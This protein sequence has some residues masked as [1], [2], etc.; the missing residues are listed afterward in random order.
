MKKILTRARRMGYKSILLGDKIAKE[1]LSKTLYLQYKVDVK[2]TN[3]GGVEVLEASTN[4][5]TDDSTTPMSKSKE[6]G[7]TPK[8]LPTDPAKPELTTKQKQWR[9]KLYELDT[10]V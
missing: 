2:K 5:G 1:V 6:E 4:S 3:T 9:V 10:L 8:V 7:C